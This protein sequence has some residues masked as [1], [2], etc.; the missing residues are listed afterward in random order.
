MK[1]SFFIRDNQEPI[2][3]EWESFARTL[4]PA[5][6][7]MTVEQLRN[8]AREL[9]GTT[10][11]DLEMPQSK[12]AQKKK[13]QGKGS[14]ALGAPETAAQIHAGMRAESGLSLDQMVFGISRVE[15]KRA[16]TLE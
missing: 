5:A 3:Q 9:L 11:R 4:R 13:S 7:D 2:L 8:H 10:A 6:K 1:L 16:P 14:R 15:G 12:S